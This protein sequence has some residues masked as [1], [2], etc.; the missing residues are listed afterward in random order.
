MLNER[1][2]RRQFLKQVS[3]IFSA[4]FLPFGRDREDRGSYVLGLHIPFRKLSDRKII[5]PFKRKILYCG[6]NTVV[7]DIKNEFGLTHIPFEHKYM[8]RYSYTSESPDRLSK[9]IDWAEVNGLR[10]IGRLCVMPDYK[11]LSVYPEFAYKRRDGSMWLGAQ[12]PW[13]NAFRL[14]AAEYNAAIAK[15]AINFGIGEINIDY[16]RFPSGEDPI[17][18][19]EYTRANN[20]QNRTTALRDYLEVIYTAVKSSGGDL[21]VDF[22][23]GTAWPESRDMGIGQHIE[24]VGHFLDGLYPM[25]YPGLSATKWTGIPASCEVGTDCPYEFV[26]LVTKLSKERL[27]SVNPSASVKTWFQAY[28]DRR[29]G[30]KMSLKEFE[31]Q[32]LAAFHGGASGI[33]A[34][35]TSLTYHWHLYKKLGAYLRKLELL[36]S[37]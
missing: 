34:W 18:Q 29:F 20:F 11:F 6:A 28:P 10:V 14:E 9:F 8:S 23:G 21:S 7:V 31:V 5:E 37:E 17:E 26:N 30:R 13:A 32:Q 33:L 36:V 22:F 3:L 1:L 12:G 16:I 27:T 24:T 35:D 19:I 4:A 25:A 2:S 15:A